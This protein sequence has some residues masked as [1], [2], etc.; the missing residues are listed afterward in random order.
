MRV[1]SRVTEQLNCRITD[2]KN[3]GKIQENHRTCK[4]YKIGLRLPAN[5]NVFNTRK[6]TPEK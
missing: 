4:N 6:K 2:L 5:I 3:L 1:V